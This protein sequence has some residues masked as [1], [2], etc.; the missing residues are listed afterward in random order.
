MRAGRIPYESLLG[1][2]VTRT[3]GNAVSEESEEMVPRV[4]I[5]DSV[6][7]AIIL[8]ALNLYVIQCLRNVQTGYGDYISRA[9]TAMTLMSSI[10]EDGIAEQTRRYED[11]AAQEF[12]AEL[13]GLSPQEFVQRI[14]NNHNDEI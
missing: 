7:R 12:S 3:K 6:D 2:T 4:V 5:R 10:Y 8:R 14:I 11:D 13:E 1:V 9:T